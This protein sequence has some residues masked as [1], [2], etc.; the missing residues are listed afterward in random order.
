M[1]FEKVSKEEFLKAC[2]K[3]DIAENIA[4]GA[5]EKIK[6]PRQ[7]TAASAG[8]DF[9]VPFPHVRILGE[10]ELTFPTGVRWVTDKET[11]RDRVLLIM[12]RSGLGFKTGLRLANTVG[13][14]DAD[15]CDA[16]NEGHIMMKLVNPKMET[17]RLECGEA[18]AQGIIVPYMICNGAESEDTRTGGFGSTDKSKDDDN[19]DEF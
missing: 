9:Y 15:Y 8:M 10:S 18:M 6:L 1:Y 14:I 19:T 3:N 2:S 17:I 12:P 11:E 7:G 16:E 5:Y 4:E 13:V